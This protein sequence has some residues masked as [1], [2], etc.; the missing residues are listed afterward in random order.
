M[1][2]DVGGF[3]NN[4]KNIY[5]EE[6][7]LNKEYSDNLEASFLDLQI[8]IENGKFNFGIFDKRDNFLFTIT[9]MPY[10][11]SN[12]PSNM[13]YSAIGAETLHWTKIAKAI[14]KADLFYSS[15]KPLLFRMIKQGTCN[16]KLSNILIFLFNKHQIY[17][18]DKAKNTQ[19]H[20][21]L[22]FK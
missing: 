21:S 16:E 17:F 15:V 10:K 20:L 11:Y 4:F 1:I 6:L 9:R 14:N 7:K 2:N 19:E 12:L 8:K 13:F 22:I 3:E 5:P 18:K